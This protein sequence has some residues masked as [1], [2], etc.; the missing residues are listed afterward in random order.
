VEKDSDKLSMKL[1]IL[2]IFLSA[3]TPIQPPTQTVAA[4]PDYNAYRIHKMRALLELKTTPKMY[5]LRIA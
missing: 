5:M 2:S 4:L 1:L 3:Q